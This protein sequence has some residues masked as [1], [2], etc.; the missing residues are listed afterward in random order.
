MMRLEIRSLRGAGAGAGAAILVLLSGC[1]TAHLE[2]DRQLST[3]IASH[4]AVVLLAKPHVEGI[5]AEDD[6][7]DCVG[8]KMAKATGILVRPNDRLEGSRRPLP[9]P[10]HE[11]VD[12]SS[13]STRPLQMHP[14]GLTRAPAVRFHHLFYSSDGPI[15]VHCRFKVF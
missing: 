1:M 14:L 6:F 2:E 15:A 13:F 10:L 8:D 9:V 5:T 12:G 11:Q 4:E 3:A 7:M